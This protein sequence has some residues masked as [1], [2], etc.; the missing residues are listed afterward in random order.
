[1]GG[2]RARDGAR[3]RVLAATGHALEFA[4]WRSLVREQ[5]L[6]DAHASDLMCRLVAA[7]GQPAQRRS[8]SLAE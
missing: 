6:D 1:M 8:A 4:T 7:A 5:G 3:R 2:R